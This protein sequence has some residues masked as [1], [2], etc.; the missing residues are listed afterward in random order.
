MSTLSCTAKD[1][2]IFIVPA[3]SCLFQL[4]APP[5]FARCNGK[6]QALPAKNSNFYGLPDKAGDLLLIAGNDHFTLGIF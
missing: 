6:S 2:Q 1:Y 3:N 4:S 5:R